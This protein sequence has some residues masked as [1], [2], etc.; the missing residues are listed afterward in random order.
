MILGLGT[1]I[2]EIE[3]VA[4]AMKQTPG[5]GRKIF[6]AYELEVLEASRYR[7]ERLAGSFAAKEA[8]SKALGTGFR[9]FSAVDIEVRRDELGKP[10]I[11]LMPK[12]K[13]VADAMGVANIFLSISH[14]KTYATATVVIEGK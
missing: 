10:F 4:K 5:F 14:C 3:R 1:D 2:I 12:A 11:V 9:T 6:T 7:G 8:M 13:Q